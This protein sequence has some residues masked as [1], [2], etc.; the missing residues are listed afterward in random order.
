MP[1]IICIVLAL[2][3]GILRIGP[4]VWEPSAYLVGGWNHPDN[5][6]NHWL[7]VWVAEQMLSLDSILHNDQYYVPFGD[8]PWLAGNGTEGI[9]F[10]PW[11]WLFGWPAGV[12]PLVLFYFIGIGLSGYWLGRVVGAGR[13]LALIPSVMLLSTP[14]WTREINAG[15]WS[16]LDGVWLIASVASFLWLWQETSTI[17]RAVVC[18]LLVGLTG[19]FY[20]Y[21]AFFFVLSATVIVLTSIVT[22]QRTPIREIAIAAGTSIVTITPVLLLFVFNWDLIPGVTETQF[23]SP[24]AL[25]DAL[26]LT[27]SWLEPFGRTAGFV[28]A[29]PV[30]GLFGWTIFHWRNV[31]H[32]QQ[33]MLLT[34]LI[35]VMLFV[36]LALGPKTPFFEFVY[37]WASPLRRFW[38]PSRH[39]LGYNIAVALV[40]SIG[41][42]QIRWRHFALCCVV[43]SIPMSLWLQ[44]D[45]PFHAMHSP[46]DWPISSYQEIGE[47]SGDVILSPPLSPKIAVTQ[48]PLLF[49][50]QHKKRLL[51]GHALW[52]DRVRP[53]Q[54]D[55]MMQSNTVLSMLQEYEEG[56]RSGVQRIDSQDMMELQNLGVELVVLDSQNIPRTHMDL[57]PNLAKIY[58]ELWGDPVWR[59]DGI[60]V[61]RTENWTGLIEIDC[62][63][64]TLSDAMKFGDGRHRMPQGEVLWGQTEPSQHH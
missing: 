15:R 2:V 10:I 50:M 24:D 7:L 36:L 26:N 12:I 22:G 20:W 57:V 62:P 9:L 49:Q 23:P 21:Y 56:R 42:Q 40:V 60:Q 16:Q 38:W 17:R 39:L 45:R 13:W 52:V 63:K 11:Y 3:I 64:R 6:G 30:L 61:W 29:L 59:G 28:L 18:G 44:G 5:L 46:I 27:G 53:N 31:P 35:L 37:G 14:Y 48:L 58:T 47:M 51:T 32:L 55:E 4:P 43:V 8:Y 41:I 34:G 33:F 54:W 1:W 19:I 25:S